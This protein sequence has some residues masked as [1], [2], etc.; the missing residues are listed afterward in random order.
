[1]PMS[2]FDIGNAIAHSDISAGIRRGRQLRAEAVLSLFNRIFHGTPADS[3]TSRAGK[4]HG[5]DA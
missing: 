2:Q 5:A 3:G 4:S 1:M